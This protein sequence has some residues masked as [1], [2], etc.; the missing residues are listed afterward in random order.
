MKL[1]FHRSFWIFV[2]SGVIKDERKQGSG[3]TLLKL[4]SD[5]GF[6]VLNRALNSTLAGLG[7]QDF[8]LGTWDGICGRDFVGRQRAVVYAMGRCRVL[9]PIIILVGMALDFSG[10]FRAWDYKCGHT[11]AGFWIQDF[12]LGALRCKRAIG[13]EC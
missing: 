12:A 13:R 7:V 6:L 2:L 5:P 9:D 10:F 1:R 3:C 8:A 11:L 4:H